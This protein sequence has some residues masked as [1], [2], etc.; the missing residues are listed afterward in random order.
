MND[1][2]RFCDAVR[3]GEDTFRC[4]N[5][6]AY[7]WCLGRFSEY[8][9]PIARYYA[10]MYAENDEDFVG[11]WVNGVGHIYYKIPKDEYLQKER[12]FEQQITDILNAA[13]G[14]D[15]DDFEKALG[16]Y[17]YMTRNFT[18]DYELMEMQGN[19]YDGP[20]N[21][22]YSLLTTG[23]AV[24]QQIG[25]LYSYLLL[26]CGVEAGE[27]SNGS[28]YPY[29]HQ[30]T[31]VVLDGK[32]YH[33]DATW[34]LTSS[35]YGD[36]GGKHMPFLTY[37]LMTDRER[38]EGDLDGAATYTMAGLGEDSRKVLDFW[39]S[40]DRFSVLHIGAEYIGMDRQNKNVRYLDDDG[41]E[42]LF[43]YGK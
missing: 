11:S 43:H 8:F 19:G 20:R 4:E 10:S 1:F 7:G 5:E 17:E 38:S 18:Y 2:F 33:A 30:W 14:D 15:Y 27:I 16:L 25:G 23:K 40:D 28:G 13:I 36:D 35:I 39:A 9:F 31:Y 41:N 24:C 42:Q 3:N 26:Q 22:V 29:N 21:T 37:F 34:G 12:E 6:D 32:G